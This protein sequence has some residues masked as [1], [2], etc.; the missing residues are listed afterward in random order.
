MGDFFDKLNEYFSIFSADVELTGLLGTDPTDIA[1]CDQ[2][3][4]RSFA[5]STLIDPSELPF[6]DFGFI[7]AHSTTRN[8]LVI[9]PPVEFNVYCSNFYEASLIYKAIHRLLTENYEDAQVGVGY[10]RATVSGIYCWSFR[11]KTMVRS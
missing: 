4:R 9:R 7:E 3:I 8:Y 11:V 10:Q 6:F 5:D 2:K 1:M